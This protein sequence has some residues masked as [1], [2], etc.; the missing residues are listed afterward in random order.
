MSR[1]PEEQHELDAAGRVLI[2]LAVEP[3]RQAGQICFMWKA[4]AP[5]RL[6]VCHQ[7]RR[8]HPFSRD[9]A[10]QERQPSIRQHEVIEE[11]TPDLARGD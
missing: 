9:V 3:V 7:Q 11:V 4:R 5:R 8:A 1:I 10:D 6:D 2:Q